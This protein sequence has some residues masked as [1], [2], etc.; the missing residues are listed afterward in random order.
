[1]QAQTEITINIIEIIPF[2]ISIASGVFLYYINSKLEKLKF[3][4]SKEGSLK[5][6]KIKTSLDKKIEEKLS[7]EQFNEHKKEMKESFDKL[8]KTNSIRFDKLEKADDEV[9]DKVNKILIKMTK[10]EK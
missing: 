9:L 3:E 10:M 2:L 8:E 6:E 7:K 4:L 1:M 5:L